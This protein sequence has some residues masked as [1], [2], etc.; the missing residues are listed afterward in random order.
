MDAGNP[1]AKRLIATLRAASLAVLMA[2]SLG[3]TACA[4]DPA[5]MSCDDFH[6]LPEERQAEIAKQL[7]ISKIARYEFSA[8]G[9]GKV[10][11][12]EA[13][14]NACGPGDTVGDAHERTK[15]ARIPDCSEYFQITDVEIR[16]AW[17]ETSAEYFDVFP[18]DPLEAL[19]G[20]CKSEPQLNVAVAIGVYDA[21]GGDIAPAELARFS[22]THAE[23]YTAEVVVTEL[24]I[25]AVADVSNAPPGFADI[26]LGTDGLVTILN[27]TE[28]RNLPTGMNMDIMFPLPL[29]SPT[30]VALTE[31]DLKLDSAPYCI[32]LPIVLTPSSVPLAGEEV[33]FKTSVAPPLGLRVEESRAQAI[34]DELNEASIAIAIGA[35]NTAGYGWSPTTP[36]CESSILGIFGH[37]TFPVA[38]TESDLIC[39]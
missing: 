36:V 22:I 26:T 24:T 7:R 18:E 23:G 16:R 1:R 35:F 3:L 34:V 15:S 31:A 4:S 9:A 8:T 29:D 12:A 32:V 27:T 14:G 25:T 21:R 11:A 28:G 2:A 37:S 30:C 38:F 33:R 6:E 17:A 10:S 19:D 20:G 5:T 39:A 13:L